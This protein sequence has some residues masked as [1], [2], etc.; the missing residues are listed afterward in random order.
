MVTAPPAIVERCRLGAGGGGK[1]AREE[2]AA[3][4]VEAAAA[5]PAPATGAPGGNGSTGAVAPTPSTS[6]TS[7]SLSSVVRSSTAA[8]AVR[9]M[10]TRKKVVEGSRGGPR[11]MIPKFADLLIKLFAIA[12]QTL[13]D[14]TPFS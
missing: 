3:D 10:K 9:A 13:P 6:S 2:A 7:M 11:D 5:E 1:E 8:D 4:E 12:L 14:F